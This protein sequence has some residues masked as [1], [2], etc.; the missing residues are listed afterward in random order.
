MAGCAGRQDAGPL[1]MAPPGFSADTFGRQGLVN[2]ATATEA[3]CRALPDGLWVSTSTGRRE[4]LRHAAAGTEGGRRTT[5]V[6]VSG[7]PEGASYRSAGGKSQIDGASE[8]Y[9]TSPEALNA[10]AQALSAATGGRPVVLLARP[11]MHGSSGDHA[12]DRHTSDE[13]EL[14]DDAL[15]QLRHRY[16]V[17]DLECVREIIRLFVSVTAHKGM[18][19]RRRTISGRCLTP[20]S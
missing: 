5:L 6:Y 12:R 13:I 17:Q 4:C 14:I 7:D 19:R 20:A 16:G 1:A 8:H 11:G 10:A 3:G 2:G 15:T 18:G 9:E